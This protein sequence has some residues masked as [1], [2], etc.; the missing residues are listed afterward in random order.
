MRRTTKDKQKQQTGN[1]YS[2]GWLDRER[3][4]TS[5]AD[6]TYSNSWCRRG[7]IIHHLKGIA[8]LN[9]KDLPLSVRREA[10][11][12][13]SRSAWTPV[14]FGV[15][16]TG[17]KKGR[18]KV[19]GGVHCSSVSGWGRCQR[20]WVNG[21]ETGDPDDIAPPKEKGGNRF[22]NRHKSKW[23]VIKQKKIKGQ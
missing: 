6:R 23:R 18:D 9:M 13:G 5:N 1:I 17:G 2:A 11:E 19:S 22:I 12:C 10:G 15:P 20:K 7:W 8:D 14:L 16:G 4:A 3:R 21:G